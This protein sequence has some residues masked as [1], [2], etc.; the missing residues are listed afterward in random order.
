MTHPA[1]TVLSLL[2]ATLLALGSA[3]AAGAQVLFVDDDA[4]GA[5]DGSSWTD[6][7]NDLASALALAT[8]GTLVWIAQGRYLPSVPTEPGDPRSATFLLVDGVG[9]GTRLDDLFI[10][11]GRANGTGVHGGVAPVFED[12]TVPGN[13]GGVGVV[14]LISSTSATIRRT[15]FSGNTTGALSTSSAGVLLLEDCLFESNS[16]E[17]FGGAV[18]IA[19]E[20]LSGVS[21][22]PFTNCSFVGN[23]AASGGALYTVAAGSVPAPGIPEVTLHNSIVWGNGDAAGAGQTS[24][25]FLQDV[26]IDVEHCAVQ[27]WDGSLGGAGNHGLDP[28]FVD[29][30]GSDDVSGTADDDLRLPVGSPCV[31]AGS[32]ALLPADTSDLDCDGN[33]AGTLADHRLTNARSSAASGLFIGQ[34]RHPRSHAVAGPP[35]AIQVPAALRT[36]SLVVP[37]WAP[38][39]PRHCG[40]SIAPTDRHLPSLSHSCYRLR[41]GWVQMAPVLSRDPRR[42]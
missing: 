12:C 21:G 31:D 10:Q 28:L 38:T 4:T 32:S 3:P 39:L 25:L 22:T 29:A 8:P 13:T 15:T 19:L 2:A 41:R 30:D 24:Q 37:E 35:R 1:R 7:F 20:S 26:T 34:Q 33:V 9:P 18:H 14:R 16:G 5:A 40:P 36:R 27:G 42:R 11:E 17:G 6:A 23:A